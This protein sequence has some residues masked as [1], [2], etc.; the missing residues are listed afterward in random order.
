MNL[1]HV[2]QHHARVRPYD[3]ALIHPTGAV[4]YAQLAG[5][6]AGLLT[7]LR[8]HGI[9]PGKAVAIYVSDP[10]LH[11]ALALAAMANG[12][13]SVS[14]HPN[15]DP[16]P[17]GTDVQACLVDRALAFTPASRVV[18]VGSNWITEI[19]HG[20][21]TAIMDGGFSDPEAICRMY[22]SSGTTGVPKLI[23][24]S[25]SRQEAMAWRGLML[26]PQAHGPNLCMMWFSTIGGWGTA[27]MT[28]MHGASLVMANDPLAVLRSINLYRVRFLRASPQQ[29]QALLEIVRGRPV[30]FPSLEKV[31]FAGAS[32]PPP[33]LLGARA[34]LC[35]N[36]V[37]V[38]G[39][40][41]VG[42]VTQAPAAVLH[43]FPDAA[44]YVAPDVEVRIVDDAGAPVGFDVEGL[45][46]VRTPQMAKSYMGDP[47]ASE[48]AFP[49]GW[50]APGDLGILRADGLLR[51]TGRADE[52]INAG[53]V[54]LSPAIVDDFL[55]T[56]P[57]IKD[58]AA[59]AFRQPGRHDEV[60]AAVVCGEGFD[61][62]AVLAA[63]AL[64]LNSRAP[65]KLVR[66]PE[67]PR[68]AM[69]KAMRQKLSAD[70]LQT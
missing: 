4:N 18:P 44:G 68:N 51:V 70:A 64:R 24:H 16:M 28:L 65:A 1:I 27:H 11:L 67:I 7:K 63:A 37:G 23:G 38:Y 56:Q 45:V 62:R 53:G 22:A 9:E 36:V 66:V 59:F 57:G 20:P 12:T 69:G 25:C 54:K 43:A 33:V 31:E 50:F 48:A 14:A 41:E 8:S 32:I 42:L 60:W 35:S 21:N 17:P 13:P 3:M 19:A 61:E 5:V 10:F 29:L 49:N 6:V 58:A 40:T 55:L 34:A 15:Y 39:S 46:R 2:I 47:K 30:R 26:D 52:M